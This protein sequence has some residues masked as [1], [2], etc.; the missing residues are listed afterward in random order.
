MLLEYCLLCMYIA[1]SAAPQHVEA[2]VISS[3]E[4][5]VSW[6]HL[7]KSSRNGIV[8]H[9]TVYYSSVPDATIVKVLEITDDQPPIL[10]PANQTSIVV[11][12][13]IPYTSYDVSVSA[14]TD[15]GEG[16]RSDAVRIATDEAS[17]LINNCNRIALDR[18]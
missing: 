1:P 6:H 3:T 17:T 14:A 5:Q 9:Y 13:L 2:I 11:N 12:Q 18:S 16:P 4:V 7:P 15:V 10:V 8:T